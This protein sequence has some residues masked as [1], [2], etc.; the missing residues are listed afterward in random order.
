MVGSVNLTGITYGGS[1]TD[2]LGLKN[3]GSG[4][5]VL[6]FQFDP[7]KTLADLKAA[8][9]STSFSGTINSLVPGNSTGV[10][11]AG[12]SM[13]LLGAALTALAIFSRRPRA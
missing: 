3:A 10:P 13:A 9:A 12:S 6:T 1:N 8:G 5:N 2:L 7:A 4:S 11:D